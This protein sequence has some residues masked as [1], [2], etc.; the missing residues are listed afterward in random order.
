MNIWIETASG[1]LLNA[2]V[3]NAIVVK[4]TTPGGLW[5]VGVATGAAPSAFATGLANRPSARAVRNALAS[6][7]ALAGS[8][9]P[10]TVYFDTEEGVCTEALDA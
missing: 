8:G 7:V 6:A 2:A 10:I 3:M 9:G 5:E 1:N 4:E